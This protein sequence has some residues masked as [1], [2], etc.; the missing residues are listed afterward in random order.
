MQVG[1]IAQEGN[2]ILA[3]PG[4][5]LRYSAEKV[6]HRLWRLE[7]LAIKANCATTELRGPEFDLQR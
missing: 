2:R 7:A 1:E 6:G 4:E 5:R 3:A